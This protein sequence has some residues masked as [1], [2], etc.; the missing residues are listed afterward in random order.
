MYK[1]YYSRFLTANPHIQHYASHSHHYWPDVTRA[2]TLQYWDDSAKWLDDKWDYIFSEK[3]PSVQKLIG[4]IL[5]LSHP[6]QIVFALNTH[7]FV[8]RLLKCLSIK[9]DHIIKIL[10]T[11]SEFYSFDRLVNRLNEEGGLELEKIATQPFDDFEKRFIEKIKNN[12]YDMIFFSQVFFN[13]GMAIKNLKTIIDNVTNK[14][15]IIVVDA[16]HGFMALPTDLSLIEDRI[17]YISGSYKYAQGGEGCCFMSVPK[18]SDY[19]PIYTGSIMDFS[20]LYRLEAVLK[21]FKTEGITVEKIHSIVQLFQKNFRDHLL[22]IDHHYL[23]EKNILSVDYNHHG[24]FLTFVMPS[25]EHAKKARDELR[26]LNIINDFRGNK[27][28]FGFGI[29]QNDCIDLTKLR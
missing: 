29:Y 3:I 5:N 2:A 19:S 20:A 9:K 21:L 15:T 8:Y 4:D 23:T 26:A 7:E 11:D 17:F 22:E 10:T 16:Y 1:K 24:H 6:E 13:S 27:L 12:H 28:R 25:M 18:N 14:N